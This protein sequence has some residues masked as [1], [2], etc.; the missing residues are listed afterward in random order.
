MIESPKDRSLIEFVVEATPNEVLQWWSEWHNRLAWEQGSTGDSIT[1]GNLRLSPMQGCVNPF[2]SAPFERMNKEE[3]WPIVVS[4]RYH[5]LNNHW[6]AFWDPTSM[7]VFYRLI[8]MWLEKTFPG[9]PT[10]NS[11]NF[12]CCLAHCMKVHRPTESGPV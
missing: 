5:R 7:L 2:C 1:V 10:C 12:Q 3:G 6:V 8:E 11:L 4:L 9:V